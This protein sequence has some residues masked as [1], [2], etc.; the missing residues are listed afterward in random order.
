MER[1]EGEIAAEEEGGHQRGSFEGGEEGGLTEK[2]RKG[3]EEEKE[4][5]SHSLS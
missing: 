4:G 2:E 1:V 5:H 3:V